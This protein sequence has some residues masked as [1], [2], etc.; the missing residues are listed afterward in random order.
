M[1][2]EPKIITEE[3]LAGGASLRLKKNES[4]WSVERRGDRNPEWSCHYLG[5]SYHAARNC[6]NRLADAGRVPGR[7]G[8]I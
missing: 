8:R 1:N 4:I 3:A 6:Y 5:R 2:R 7:N